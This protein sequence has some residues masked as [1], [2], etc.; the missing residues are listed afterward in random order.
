MYCTNVTE[1]LRRAE[2]LRG[3]NAGLVRL[4]CDHGEGLLKDVLQPIY[5]TATL[6]S[7]KSCFC[8]ALEIRFNL[9]RIFASI[10]SLDLTNPTNV[11]TSDLKVIH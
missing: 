10:P 9:R 5:G 7:V 6:D 8:D 3:V 2:V 4:G 11:F 1:L